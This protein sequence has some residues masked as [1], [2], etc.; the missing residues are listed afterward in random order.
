LL[1][2]TNPQS[3]L[4]AAVRTH[5]FGGRIAIT[6]RN[7]EEAHRLQEGGGVDLVLYP[8]DDAATSAANQI[9][10][11]D[12]ESTTKEAA[13]ALAPSSLKGQP[14]VIIVG[15]SRVGDL[16]GEMLARHNVPYVALDG[17]SA[18]VA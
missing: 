17:D 5:R 12:E 10:D 6:A 15:S 16:V 4:L 7:D 9:T 8:F 14:R 11:L 2:E 18:L 13:K 1:T 3:G